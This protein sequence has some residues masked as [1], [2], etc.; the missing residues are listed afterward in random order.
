ME[1]REKYREPEILSRDTGELKGG[2]SSGD[3][4]QTGKK[5]NTAPH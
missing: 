5:D 2:I 4:R 1:R 3:L